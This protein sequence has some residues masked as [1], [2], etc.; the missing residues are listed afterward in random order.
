MTWL[1]SLKFVPPSF[2]CNCWL[3]DANCQLWWTGLRSNIK[4]PV[5][6]YLESVSIYLASC[7]DLRKRNKLKIRFSFFL[8]DGI[9]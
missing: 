9:T 6:C 2:F 8:S 7:L 4:M 1:L 5:E 3:S